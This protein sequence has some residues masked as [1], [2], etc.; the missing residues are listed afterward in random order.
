MLDS[1]SFTYFRRQRAQRRSRTQKDSHRRNSF[2]HFTGNTQNPSARN[3]CSSNIL[4]NLCF[5]K[6]KKELISDNDDDGDGA[7]AGFQLDWFSNSSNRHQIL[8]VKIAGDGYGDGDGQDHCQYWKGII[9]CIVGV[10][11]G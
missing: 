1:L 8:F 9:E 6:R 10:H 3:F 11:V 2:G 7:R 5:Y 4:I